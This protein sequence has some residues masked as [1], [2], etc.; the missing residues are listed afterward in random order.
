MSDYEDSGGEETEIERLEREAR[1]KLSLEQTAA[2][3]Q[4]QEA[5]EEHKAS[6]LRGTGPQGSI[7]GTVPLPTPPSDVRDELEV[8]RNIQKAYSGICIAPADAKVKTWMPIYECKTCSVRICGGCRTGLHHGHVFE[9]EATVEFA[10]CESPSDR[11]V[12]LRSND[13]KRFHHFKI[14]NDFENDGKSDLFD[15]L[16]SLP[17]L[18]EPD[19]TFKLVECVEH[20]KTVQKYVDTSFGESSWKSIT[21][22]HKNPQIYVQPVSATSIKQG[23][24]GDCYLI[25]AVAS[26]SDRPKM[27][28]QSILN[29]EV[30]PKGVYTVRL[31]IGGAEVF[32]QVDD[33]FAYSGKT[34]YYCCSDANP[35]EFYHMLIEKAYA[36]F[37]GGYKNIEGGFPHV[38]LAEIT[39]GLS[40]SYDLRDRTVIQKLSSYELIKELSARIKEDNWLCLG[41]GG[42]SD[43]VTRQNGIVEGHAYSLLDMRE[44]IHPIRNE[45]IILFKVR[46]PWGNETEWT[47][48]FGD[49]SPLWTDK[50]KEELDFV[51]ASDGTWWMP[52]DAIKENFNMLSVCR[53]VDRT[54][55]PSYARFPVIFQEEARGYDAENPK[56]ARSPQFALKLVSDS[57]VILHVEHLHTPARANAPPLKLM[58]F[59][60]QGGRYDPSKP[61]RPVFESLYCLGT[62]LEV[63]LKASPF[64]YTVVIAAQSGR[65]GTVGDTTLAFYGSL[66]RSTMTRLP[67]P[68][69][70]DPEVWKACHTV[71][72]SFSDK[73]GVWGA[74]DVFTNP[75]FHIHVKKACQ[76]RIVKPPTPEPMCV[77][78]FAANRTTTRLIAPTENLA[79]ALLPTKSEETYNVDVSRTSRFQTGLVVI[80]SLQVAGAMD[81]FNFSILCNEKDAISVSQFV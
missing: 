19:A 39:G 29:R 18:P 63:P 77:Q 5:V 28:T 23:R 81:K 76:I 71:T 47:G 58:V 43:T 80:P 50:L 22:V 40:Y 3:K 67:D 7:P 30:N 34:P 27:L 61:A 75:Q 45:P 56:I 1:E 26:V 53:Y 8:A 37:W 21:S 74:A 79:A 13:T 10:V 49:K 52:L 46:N 73:A 78:M 4:H 38:T 36:K 35:H 2:R 65:D 54:T 72:G 70:T 33:R 57:T 24:L 60:L 42:S 11:F 6:L 64:P 17:T 69:A 44:V 15:D 48:D 9:T 20:G 31:F 14:A 59:A 41:S 66:P 32:V 51:D 62:L 25:A 68:Q 16:P 12:A 55:W